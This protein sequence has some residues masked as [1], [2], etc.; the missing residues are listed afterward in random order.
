MVLLL[1]IS[2]VTFI[3]V[4]LLT[5]I[6][7]STCTACITNTSDANNSP[8]PC[9][10]P[11]GDKMHDLLPDIREL[12]WVADAMVVMLLLFFCVAFTLFNY[13]NTSW[14]SI[15]ASVLILLSLKTITSH[16]TCLPDSSQICSTKRFK[17]VFG[18]CNDL[19][20]SVHSSIV[21]LIVFILNDATHL[22]K[23]VIGKLAIGTY[24]G[25][26]LLI[27]LATRNHYTIDV[28]MAFFVTYFVY[29][30]IISK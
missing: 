27:I 25:T 10:L 5:S 18:Q 1:A 17:Y 22:F 9:N 3:A 15:A 24:V 23:S 28:I 30:V 20:F 19:M 4:K 16:V 26:T 29:K 11:L 6:K 21:F 12:Y 13:T 14:Y 2:I 8:C 7:T